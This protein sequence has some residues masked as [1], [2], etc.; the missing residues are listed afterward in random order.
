MLSSF[1]PEVLTVFDNDP[2]QQNPLAIRD[3][4]MFSFSEPF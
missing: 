2:N 1:N 3:T 4:A